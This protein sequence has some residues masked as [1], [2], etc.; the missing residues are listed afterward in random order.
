MASQVNSAVVGP[1]HEVSSGVSRNQKTGC[2][3]ELA[4]RQRERRD[5][6]D[7]D[8]ERTATQACSTITV[9]MN[10]SRYAIDGH[11]RRHTAPMSRVAV[12]FAQR[13]LTVRSRTL[14]PLVLLALTVA[15]MFP[16]DV[17]ALAVVIFGPL[18][19]VRELRCVVVA[20]P[21]LATVSFGIPIA[22]VAALCV[23]LRMLGAPV[24]LEVLCFVVAGTFAFT[25]IKS[26]VRVAAPAVGIVGMAVLL[27]LG[28]SGAN[29]SWSGLSL[30]WLV[31]IAHLHNVLPVVVAVRHGGRTERV[32]AAGYVAATATILSGS[33]DRV[34]QSRWDSPLT[35]AAIGL[36]VAKAAKAITPP[37]LTGAWPMRLLVV[38]AFGQLV[39]YAIWSVVLRPS[40]PVTASPPGPSRLPTLGLAMAMT[41]ALLLVATSSWADARKVYTTVAV[42]HIV[43]ELPAL[44]ALLRRP[45]TS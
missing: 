40:G 13:R 7:D 12:D 41:V 4:R 44:G 3:V 24:G 35:G 42:V 33:L 18:H 25:R 19:V 31:A 22:A 29:L 27:D 11:L 14:A 34:V 39:H 5:Q 23:V 26:I 30:W 32:V 37:G 15:V 6:R 21:R 20:D 28:G 9:S 38:F 8:P 1:S 43:F 45:R 16:V 10:A 2:E 36:D 17:A